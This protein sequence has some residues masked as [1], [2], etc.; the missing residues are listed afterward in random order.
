M[1]LAI[2]GIALGLMYIMKGQSNNSGEQEESFA[3]Q[4]ALPN[5]D[6]PNRNYPN[7][8]PVRNDELDRTSSL[9]TVNKFE[10]GGSVYT[11]KYFNANLVAK[12]EQVSNEQTEFYSLTGEKVAGSY[13][14]HNNMVP[15]FGAKMRTQNAGPNA[16]EGIL[17][18]YTGSGSQ[19]ITKKEQ[20]PLF[21]PSDSQN[22]GNGAPNMNDFYQSRVNKSMRMANTKPFEEERVA[23]GLGLGYTNDGA[24]G[25]NSGMMARESWMPKTADDLRVATNPKSSGHVLLGHEGPAYSSIKNIATQEQMGVM[26]KNRQDQSF[27]LDT[28]S[29]ASYSG[30]RHP[31]GANSDI[32]R[33]FITTGAG[34]GETLHSMPI[35]RHVTRPETAVSYSG[36]AASQNSATYVPGEY[37]PSH[38]VQLGAV[39][40][41]GANANGRNHATDA[42]YGIKSK[43]AYPNNRTSNTQNGYFGMVGSSIGAVVAPLLDALRPSRKQNVIGNLRPY[44]NP[45]TTVP[46]SY[47][48]NPA[49]RPSTTIRETTENSKNHLNVNANQLGGAYQVTDQQSYDTNRQSTSTQYV[50][51]AGAGDGTRQM[52]SYEA[53][54]N[55]RNNDIK[56]STI[57]GYMVKGNMNM[58]NSNINMREKTRDD[59]LRNTRA[60]AGTMP[61]QSPDVGNMGRLAGGGNSLYSNINMDR[62]T[63]DIMDTLKQN[64]YVVNYKNAL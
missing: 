51:G 55:Q 45:G 53:E 23:P 9:S 8:Y 6:I 34:K 42:D 48:F 33:L 54:Y 37:M 59:S 11:D 26:E 31:N 3:N 49:D 62:N 64:P 7:E 4:N 25:F 43:K 1:E 44:Q 50:G 10:N 58:L 27:E 63:P 2:P 57:D 12:R 20:A 24:H 30:D 38:N 46:S 41:A 18:N 19:T 52:K 17:D 22:W 29:M 21:A 40:I 61:G 32:G 13:F 28:R 47:I 35:D 36:V 14:S 5:T 39:P 16:N 60:I 15:F 56:S